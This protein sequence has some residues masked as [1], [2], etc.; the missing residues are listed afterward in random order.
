MANLR[1]VAIWALGL[2]AAGTVGGLLGTATSSAGDQGFGGAVAGACAFAC[3]RLW[4][5]ERKAS[6]SN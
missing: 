4:A 5:G 2:I 6:I 3:A 1:A